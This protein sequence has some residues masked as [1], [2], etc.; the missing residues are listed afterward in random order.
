MAARLRR[1]APLRRPG[2][3][4]APG[5][6]RAALAL[7][8]ALAAGSAV[9]GCGER[10]GSGDVGHVSLAPVGWEVVSRQR[11]G[12]TAFEYELRGVLENAGEDVSGAVLLL[13]SRVAAT[14][15]LAG[16]LHFGP[17]AAKGRARSLDTIRIRHDRAEPF[18]PDSLAWVALSYGPETRLSERRLDRTHFEFT[19]FAHLI[20][21]T[22]QPQRFGARVEST[23]P[24]STAVVDE[25]IEAETVPALRR[26][27]SRDVFAI[28]QDRSVPFDPTA[29]VWH[30]EL[31][32][33]GGDARAPLVRLFAPSAVQA[34]G[35]VQI[36]V[37]AED[38]VGVT[39]VELFVDG[40]SVATSAQPTP[41]FSYTAPDRAGGSLAIRV[42]ARDAAGNAGE[43]SAGVAVLAAADAAPPVIGALALPPR[44][45][46]GTS[47]S[48]RAQVSD[49]RGVAEVRFSVAG[50]PPV[51]D[52]IPPFDARLAVPADAPVGG[53]ITVA[54]EAVDG[55]GL[56][57]QA[58]GQLLVV[59]QPDTSAPTGV[60]L[61]APAQAVAGSAVD[62]TATASDDVGVDA[63]AFA[64][65]GVGVGEDAE[66][67]YA[68]SV[69]LPAG[70]RPGDTVTW[71]ARAVD[72]AGNATEATATTRVVAP[73]S[74]FAVGEVYD[75]ATGR[76]LAGVA[77][78]V[79]PAGPETTTDARGV[80][81]LAL[82]EGNA[83]LALARDGYT[84]AWREI[85]VTAGAVRAPLD[86]RLAPRA[87][88]VAVT[89]RDGG[90]LAAGGATLE[91][92]VGA[93]AADASV[94]LTPLSGQAL[95]APLPL[96]WA[97][98]AAFE[99]EAG[100]APLGA[101]LA[102][103]VSGIDAD[104]ER[105]VGVR[106]DS[107]TRRWL[108]VA[109]D[110]GQGGQ[111]RLAVES[112]GAV[113]IARRDA[114][115]EVPP[116]AEPGQPLSGVAPRA[117]PD[118][119]SAELLPSPR[120]LF[121]ASDA[122]ARV[123][124]RL[125]GSAALPSGTPIEVRFAERYT[126]LDGSSL[127]PPP[128]GQDLLLYPSAD[129]PESRFVASPAAELDASALREG[130]IDLAAQ[131]APGAAPAQVFGASGG[132]LESDAARATIPPGALAAPT[133]VALRSF[134]PSDPALTSDARFS[135]LGGVELDLGGF[136]LAKGAELDLPAPSG[137]GAG[138]QILVLRPLAV[139]GATR[140]ELVALARASGGRIAL[141][142]PPA[143][144]PLPGVVEGDRYAFVRLAAP[145][146]F[147]TG[148]VSGPGAA[149][150]SDVLVSADTLPFV[151]RTEPGAARY[152]VAASLGPARVTGLDLQRGDAGEAE[153]S[154]PGQDVV[155]VRDLAL[156]AGRPRVV[157]VDP[158]DG[159][160]AVAA[161]AALNAHFDRPMDAASA[162]P[163]S[164][165][166]E[167]GGSRIPGALALAADGRAL[168]FRPAAPLASETLHTLRLA[169]SLRDAFGNGLEGNQPDGAFQSS[170]T[171][172][173]TTPPPRPEAGQISFAPAGEGH[174]HVAGTQGAAE[175]GAVV[176][177]VNPATG[178]SSS[179][180][181]GADGS[182][183]LDI[184][185]GF[186]DAIEL[187][188]RDAAGNETVEALG[189]VPPP[190]GVGV[191]GS[192]GGAVEGEAGMAAAIPPAVLPAD[193]V[194]RL[195]APDPASVPA[196]PFP[197]E[198][199]VQ[200]AAAAHLEL[201]GAEIPD[202]VELRLEVVGHPEL[203]VVDD[204]PLFEQSRSL[205]VPGDATPGTPLLLRVI[206]V[207]ATGHE[208]TLEAELPIVA[209]APDATPRHLVTA[210]SPVVSLEL[211][212]QAT[213]GQSV[214]IVA[215]V[216]YAD[217]KLRFP[218]AAALRGSEQ[219]LVWE[220]RQVGSHVLYNLLD[221]AS[222]H[223]AAD[224]SRY[225][226]TNSP[227][228]RGIRRDISTLVLTMSQEPQ[229]AMLRTL[230]DAVTL[231]GAGIAGVGAAISAGG[232]VA[233]LDRTIVGA[234]L[235]DRVVLGAL[236]HE[237]L[238]EFDV[239]P[240]RAGVPA[241]IQVVNLETN[242]VLATAQVQAL[243]PGAFS[244]VVVLGE[245]GNAP[246]VT[247]T[248]SSV[249]GSVPVDAGLSISFSHPI[250][251]SSIGTTTL[252]LTD[253]QGNLVFSDYLFQ[254]SSGPNGQQPITIIRLQ[255]RNPLRPGTI[256][257][258]HATSGIQ[259][260]GGLGLAQDYTMRFMTGAEPVEVGSLPVP[261]VLHF[262][263]HGDY[264]ALAVSE[265]PGANLGGPNLTNAVMTVDVSDPAHPVVS[266]RKDADYE[267]EGTV[268]DVRILPAED[269]LRA[270]VPFIGDLVAATIGDESVFSS[271]QLL[272]PENHLLR[273]G[274]AVVSS[275]VSVLNQTQE[276]AV[277][278]D[279]NSSGAT[280]D[281]DAFSSQG[282][283][284]K[285]IP[286]LPATPTFLDSDGSGFL[287]F[288][289]IP[290]GI[291]TLD[292]ARAVPPPPVAAR[293]TQ[294]GPTFVPEDK[295]GFIA[296]APDPSL[297]R[298]SATLALTTPGVDPGIGSL[299][300]FQIRGRVLDPEV[301]RVSVNTV[302]AQLSL[303]AD[304]TRDFAVTLR[305]RP[306]INTL[307]ATPFGD[308]GDELPGSVGA[309][310]VVP[311]PPNPLIGPGR[312]HT[313]FE[314][315]GGFVLLDH[316]PNELHV[317]A[318]VD[319]GT[320]DFFDALFVNGQPASAKFCLPGTNPAHNSCGWPGRG[321]VSVP[322]TRPVQ[323]VVATAVDTDAS[324]QDF[325][326]VSYQDLSVRE[327]LVAAIRKPDPS[328]N[329]AENRLDLLDASS[330][331]RISNVKI[332]SGFRVTLVPRVAVDLDG[333][334]R[335]GAA[336]NTDG[337]DQTSWDELRSL[338][339][340]GG[341]DGIRF[342]DVTDPINP[343]SIGSI[344]L[345]AV[346]GPSFKAFALPEQGIAYVAAGSKLLVVDLRR[347]V[348]GGAVLGPNLAVQDTRI[349]QT[350]AVPGGNA[351][352]VIVDEKRQLIYVLQQGIGVRIFRL[353]CDQDVGVDATHR[354]V[355]F[356]NPFNSYA[357][358]RADLNKAIDDAMA[359]P[360]CSAFSFT[361]ASGAN[362][363]LLAQGSSACLWR[364]DGI[365]SSAFQRAN[366]DYDF[367]FVYA[368]GMTQGAAQACSDEIARSMRN[369]DAGGNPL[370]PLPHGSVFREVSV[371]AVPLADLVDAYRAPQGPCGANGD[372]DGDLCLGRTGL[373]LKWF[374]EGEFVY[375]G[376]PSNR[377]DL[378]FDLEDSGVSLLSAPRRPG[379]A[380]FTSAS[381]SEPTHVP[382]LEGLE[383]ACQSGFAF[384][385]SGARFR[386]RGEGPPGAD[387][388]WPFF[389]NELHKAA[390]A[391]I[392]AIYGRLLADPAT[393]RLLLTTTRR[394]YNS[395]SGCN[396][397]FPFA[398]GSAPS[399]V[400]DFGF[401]RCESFEEYVASAAIQSVRRR[402]GPLSGAD[403]L[404]A[405]EMFRVKSDV[406][407]AIATEQKANEFVLRA[408]DLV[409]RINNATDVNAS[410][411]S[412]VQNYADAA[413][414]QANLAECQRR[415]AETKASLKLKVPARVF[416]GGF[417]PV[418]DVEVNAYR[419]GAELSSRRVSLTGGEDRFLARLLFE[420]PQP[421]P[422]QVSA[423]SFV[424]DPENELVE[425]DKQNNVAGFFYYYLDGS[426]PFANGLALSNAATPPQTPNGAL[427]PPLPPGVHVPLPRSPE[428]NAA[429][430]PPPSL[431]GLDFSL[432][433]AP[434]PFGTNFLPGRTSAAA[435]AGQ[436]VEL[437][438]VVRNTGNVDLQGVV[439]DTSLPCTDPS[440]L[441]IGTLAAG[442]TV[443][444]SCEI[445][446]P[447][448]GAL[449]LSTIRADDASGL[450][451][452]VSSA[453]VELQDIKPG[454]PGIEP[455]IFIPG[456]AGSVLN[457]VSTLGGD[458]L[459][460]KGDKELLTLDPQDP[461]FPGVGAVEAT[462]AMRAISIGPISKDIYGSFLKA[463]SQG[464]FGHE[465]YREYAHQ[466]PANR[467]AAGCQVP[468]P[469]A[470]KPTLFVFPW[471]WRI[472]V[473]L[474]VSQLDDYVRCV[475]MIHGDKARIHLVAHSMGGLVAR[476]YVLGHPNE[477]SRI[478]TLG[479]P[480][481]GAAKGTYVMETG[482][483][484]GVPSFVQ[485][486]VLISPGLLRNLADFFP[487]AHE[488]LPAPLYFDFVRPLAEPVGPSPF[489]TSQPGPFLFFPSSTVAADHPT[490]RRVMDQLLHR[491]G[492]PVQNNV[493]LHGLPNMDDA[494]SDDVQSLYHIVYGADS[495]KTIQRVT[496]QNRAL[497]RF[498][499]DRTAGLAG[500]AVSA[501][502]NPIA[503]AAAETVVQLA[504]GFVLNTK[505]VTTVT[506]T[507]GDGTVP[508]ASSMRIQPP[509]PGTS[510][511]LLN[512]N[513]PTAELYRVPT[514]LDQDHNGMLAEPLVQKYV[515]SVL[516]PHRV[517][518]QPSE[519]RTLCSASAPT[520]RDLSSDSG[521]LAE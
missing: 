74:G 188:L 10:V 69:P 28:R 208:E 79:L 508:A 519:R 448:G 411:Q 306:G 116:L 124:A 145:A 350:I 263:A 334:G 256:Y 351:R 149:P 292:L 323:A 318:S 102:L 347:A 161:L 483:F 465:L 17:I 312:V 76:P 255:P 337:D 386:I 413:V 48:A 131:P 342:I 133:P 473:D 492:H 267:H 418:S 458:E 480:Y 406:G 115:P 302:D 305:L 477:I 211:P 35:A 322:I 463:F 227:P 362:A 273:V 329:E 510:P 392:R 18:D 303:R 3:P 117:V 357:N 214:R 497:S 325:K 232:Q 266:N 175:P 170:F 122:R 222:L 445:T 286:E 379:D 34:G 129:G 249:N 101:P 16:E 212:T 186:L 44:A 498:L 352:D 257:T 243:A 414:R 59:A 65:G 436:N 495:E 279:I 55:A 435:P 349:L 142:A 428:C 210:T 236:Q 177:L 377:F 140:W 219:M 381:Y 404:L 330:M 491:A 487:G 316:L 7:L 111:L 47:F 118:G 8:A 496:I 407:P 29:L 52:R 221:S 258:L 24:L 348:S 245:D 278:V 275:D 455:V 49:D 32:S 205:A 299:G 146:G 402:M 90:S 403:A 282:A 468:A 422:G 373:M 153:A 126:R 447:P 152:A 396:T 98:L 103:D 54:V 356:E 38:D 503:G 82:A 223:V 164:V 250:D 301:Q 239:I 231:S 41:V 283:S 437:R 15:V 251:R 376:A 5:G 31:G 365:C 86:A 383:W 501:E 291:A 156:V 265:R 173:D 335:T 297:V 294:L 416:D 191:V 95:P 488:L 474:A 485:T 324:F 464:N 363:G 393:N 507:P 63:V 77:V 81:R 346:G 120:V 201:G 234:A 513:A 284:F 104:A 70:A 467:T 470:S 327:G 364:D 150:A 176:F 506:G 187:R 274:G 308:A 412:S 514:A 493:A 247:G 180:L 432:S 66:A 355:S 196:P 311:G 511:N 50:A 374:L 107:A 22:K 340:V 42:V 204:V 108:R 144:L 253:A 298:Q 358:L 169:A 360:A 237:N 332:G 46:P 478:I 166:L 89:Q 517:Q 482:D 159:A 520:Q 469:G 67:P 439:I 466:V 11:V 504:G 341:D 271:V 429:P 215:K 453:A 168:T 389:L 43:A 399:S 475:R 193:S 462:D 361:P 20:N 91:V 320:T 238:Y 72:F 500:D 509:N 300:A 359:E 56:S 331:T 285:G 109:L 174:V 382:L 171:T 254:P 209:S 490:F 515:I 165:T 88:P 408:A 264:L 179:V 37:D 353:G 100:A 217:L 94:A 431:P 516:Q 128:M 326:G 123:T 25:R 499:V 371:F 417:L 505:D 134:T 228:F 419:D 430:Q 87:P 58:S 384:E 287:H 366:S 45:A 151:S 426:G 394:D 241:S 471:D 39:G 1:K 233:N 143:G 449:V 438:W 207:D 401:K 398:N 51:V 130:S 113:A 415:T 518:L 460:P 387:V 198:D 202:P 200:V 132:T 368:P 450:S 512:L 289:N 369:V 290:V 183:A 433:A 425:Y 521:C 199:G 167:A 259:R 288:I 71:T 92:G 135:V 99:V 40:L 440:Q 73:G 310:V 197:P 148:A 195:T 280:R 481:L 400:D 457:L 434:L 226:E 452:G 12:R 472:G 220:V 53:R 189:R 261:G 182:F 272:S 136:V 269:L 80:Y 121:A 246:V 230:R 315:V 125:H 454:E 93:L 178:H 367:E 276:L 385:K 354:P 105:T 23:A 270:G 410:Y 147:V 218:A 370:P 36:G 395:D 14:E 345:G 139:L 75:D 309:R 446:V 444:P 293:G 163:D 229:L 206:G 158:A 224:G 390:K 333:D 378:G 213:P 380:V 442:A 19:Y 328:K 225:V 423:V 181:A 13:Q 155:V 61:Q 307:I 313:D 83:A 456:M 244:E 314:S 443:T 427:T 502:V 119:S 30:I 27:G 409:Q 486:L 248:T 489:F 388:E 479:T 304:G 185:A 33:L 461:N 138:D 62:L 6:V 172:A 96:G 26:I 68:L 157:S 459:W 397:A 127:E 421:P 203:G 391:G 317:V 112:T 339:V 336:E 424:V 494:T 162:T 235:L 9:T 160:T 85:Q 57:A 240:V 277:V 451:A 484:I 137:V 405:H 338:A 154:L 97:P 190:P 216:E 2:S 106:F 343:K 184:D 441:Q 194:V 372:L 114:A 295:S 260:V 296:V 242:A 64:A 84:N 78:R 60:A 252:F 375:E 4:R 476:R 262:D 192:S 110:A 141:I 319:P 344:L 420:F 281:L 21:A 268:H 321:E